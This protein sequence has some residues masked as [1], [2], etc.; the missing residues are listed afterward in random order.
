VELPDFLQ[1]ALVKCVDGDVADS[2]I[3]DYNGVQVYQAVEE[4]MGDGYLYSDCYFT[5][6]PLA[7]SE[8]EYAFTL[9]NLPEIPEEALPKYITMFPDDDGYAEEKRHFAYAIDTGKLSYEM[10]NVGKPKAW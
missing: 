3:L 2:L 6:K 1:D 8:S 7:G 9:D 5:T 4:D 10:V